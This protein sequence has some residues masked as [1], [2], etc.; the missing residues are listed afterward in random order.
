MIFSVQ[1]WH[2]L[3]NHVDVHRCMEAC[4]AWQLV[5]LFLFFLRWVSVLYSSN[6][7]WGIFFATALK[8]SNWSCRPAAYR[9]R[10]TPIP[11]LIGK[12]NGIPHVAQALCGILSSSLVLN[13]ECWAL[14]TKVILTQRLGCNSVHRP[15]GIRDRFQSSSSDVIIG[16]LPCHDRPPAW[17]A[18]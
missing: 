18:L 2:K 17:S 5:T 16:L 12:S 15:S 3:V 8:L 9:T 4:V 7:T 1:L 11:L 13:S 10:S 6:T 14:D